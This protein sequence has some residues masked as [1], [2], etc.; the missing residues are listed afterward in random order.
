[1]R[2]LFHL[3]H[4]AHF[5]LFKL[6]ILQLQSEG[7]IVDVLIKKKDVLEDLL[8]NAQI[9]YQNILP[10]GRSDSKLGIILGLLRQNLRLFAYVFQHRPKLMLGTS[11]S[12]GHVGRL[13][14][15]C[16]WNFNEDDAAAVPFYAKLAYPFADRIFSPIAC[17]NG[18]WN[19]KTHTYPSYHELAYLHPE[20]FVASRTIA[21]QYVDTQKPYFI[22]RFAKLTAHHDSGIGGISDKWVELIVDFLKSK[23]RVYISA[24]RS[25][26]AEFEHLKIRVRPLDLHHVMAFSQLF[27]GDSQTMAAESAALG[28]P[29][30]RINDFVGRLGYLTELE[31]T[32]GLG[33]GFRP[34][35]SELAYK[36]IV[37]LCQQ[38]NLNKTWNKKRE[39]M[40][41]QRLNLH[42]LQMDWLH[43]FIEK[44]SK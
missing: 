32:Y 39:K 36:K 7:H 24:E 12:I 19:G 41:Q 8:Q 43:E 22:L 9:L 29:F 25:L 6:S 35:Q 16:N 23:G 34:V 4:P 26:K 2:F 38:P 30:V 44:Q 21:Q 42:S 18:K 40:L 1:M 37:E 15:I 10:E 17:E 31:E 28:V 13:L 3:G 14:G 5:H 33:F 11:V 20:N 27:V